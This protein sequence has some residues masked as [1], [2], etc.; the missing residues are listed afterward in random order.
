MKLSYIP[1]WI[2]HSINVVA[3]NNFFEPSFG[4][5]LTRVAKPPDFKTFLLMKNLMDLKL[6]F[7]VFS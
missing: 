7:N 4:K 3:N 2:N 6:L 5:Y 1:I